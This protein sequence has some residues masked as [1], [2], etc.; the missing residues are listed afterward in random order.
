MIRAL[1]VDDE[2]LARRSIRI[3]LEADADVEVVGECADGDEAAERLVELKPDLLF[4]DIRM[5]GLDGFELLERV[6]VD[7]VPVVIFVTAF[8]DHAVRAFDNHALDYV[9][10][11]FDDDRFRLALD[12][13][14]SRLRERELGDYGRRI[15]AALTARPGSGPSRLAVHETGRIRFVEIASIDWISGAGNYVEL[16]VGDETVLHREP[17]GTLEQ[18]LDGRRFAR[19]HRSTIV[20]VDRVKELRAHGHGDC[21]VVLADGTELRMSRS[22]RDRLL[23]FLEPGR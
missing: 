2:P 17:L 4:L 11:P 16:H 3:L 23:K 10:K 14:K 7:T 20:N 15:A 19:I 6:G 5:P 8:D 13:A 9:L 22:H 21:V 1:I 12:R 18:R